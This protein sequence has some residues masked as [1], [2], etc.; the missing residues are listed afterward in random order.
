[1]TNDKLSPVMANKVYDILVQEC[2][3]PELQRASFVHTQTT[4]HCREWRFCGC[5]G[6]GGK[7]WNT[8]E[9][10]YVNCYTEDET[11]ERR[12]M[13]KRTNILLGNLTTLGSRIVMS[14]P[15]EAAAKVL[16]GWREKDP[17]LMEMLK[18]LGVKEIVEHDDGR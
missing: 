12:T 2:G 1:M 9:K 17:R 5:L 13:I 14:L 7:F 15:I 8:N 18:D 6:F 10:L 11:S 3:A 16:K 4:E